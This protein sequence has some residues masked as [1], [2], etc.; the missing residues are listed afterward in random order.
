MAV[1]SGQRQGTA[2]RMTNVE[3][4]VAEGTIG[5]AVASRV[6]DERSEES[7]AQWLQP[8]DSRHPRPAASAAARSRVLL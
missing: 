7:A 8:P 6:S 2:W 1:G 4:G 3:D 5:A